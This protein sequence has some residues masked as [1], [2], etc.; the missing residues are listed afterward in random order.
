[1][2]LE[3]QYNAVYNRKC[4]R[5]SIIILDSASKTYYAQRKNI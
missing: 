4:I 5:C 2:F 3:Y 1:M